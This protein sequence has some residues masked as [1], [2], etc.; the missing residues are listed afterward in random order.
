MA[1][2]DIGVDEILATLGPSERRQIYEDLS[3]EFDEADGPRLEGKRLTPTEEDFRGIL[4]DIWEYRNLLTPE[5]MNRVANILT[6]PF[7]Q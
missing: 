2:F 6:E 7:V 5:Q 1:L 4:C 3:E